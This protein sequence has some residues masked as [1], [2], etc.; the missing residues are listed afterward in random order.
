MPDLL[1]KLGVPLMIGFLLGL[2][3]VIWVQPASRG[4]QILLVAICMSFCVA[5]MA[6]WRAGAFLIARLRQNRHD[7][8]IAP[9]PEQ[10]TE[11]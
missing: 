7:R 3:L 5:L 9:S 2:G 8:E 10:N 1:A 11:G 4:G 6:L